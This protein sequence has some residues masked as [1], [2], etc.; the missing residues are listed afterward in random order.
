[1]IQYYLD[2]ERQVKAVDNQGLSYGQIQKI[3]STAFYISFSIRTPGKTNYLYIGRGGGHEGVWCGERAPVTAIRR[4]DNFLEY[5]RK[6]M[7]SCS[8]ISLEL[9]K[10]D[11]IVKFNYQKFGQIQSFLFFWR[12]R[13][14]YFLHHYQEGPELP[15]KLLLS[16]KGKTLVANFQEQDLFE[17]FNEVGRRT[18]MQHEYRQENLLSIQELLELEEKLVLQ[19]GATSAPTF[20]Q[21]KFGNITQ[22]L[23]RARQWNLL[24]ELINKGDEF[25]GRELKVGA[26]KIKFEGDLN[27]YER[28]NL[29]FEK[30]KKLKRGEE[31]LTERLKQTQELLEGGGPRSKVISTLAMVK[32]VWGKDEARVIEV[33]RGADKEE[34]RVYR[35]EGY[36]IGVGLNSRGNDQLRNNWSSKEDMWIHLD[37]LKSAHCIVKLHSRVSFDA[38]I[39]NRAA[40]IVAHYSH[41]QDEWI[42]IIYTSVKNLKGVSGAPGMVIFKKEKHLKCPRLK[43]IELN[44][45]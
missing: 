13:K 10:S 11:R 26:Q 39:L 3:Y 27:P 25:L 14:L 29:V 37:G 30:I 28:R 2:L 41:F 42:P 45:E 15:F 18:D 6:H 12:A 1:M 31:I 22:D 36:S 17:Y 20:L 43:D 8:F 19:K 35:Y 21:R 5:F 32:P 4:K 24:Q 16:W 44:K 38:E 33:P 40:T 7:S 23:E 34:Y 9:D